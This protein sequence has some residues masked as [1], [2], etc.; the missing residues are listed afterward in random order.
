M[1]PIGVITGMIC[2]IRVGGSDLLRATIGRARE[3]IA[4]PEKE[5]MSSMSTETREVWDGKA[6]VRTGGASS[7]KQIIHLPAN[8][9]DI[10]P[11]SFVTLESD[12]QDSDPKLECHRKRNSDTNPE[13]HDKLNFSA[14]SD[15][16]PNISLNCQESISSWESWVYALLATLCQLGVIGWSGVI[17]L[18]PRWKKRLPAFKPVLGFCLLAAGTL[19]L[20]ISMWMCAQVVDQGTV[21]RRWVRM[22]RCRFFVMVCSWMEIDLR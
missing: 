20:T 15:L 11:A 9:R 2:A 4:E 12:I 18:S 13:G 21:E 14:T 22:V 5:F 6:I 19:L 3:S 10:S 17:C 1:A 7:V 8:D 16:P